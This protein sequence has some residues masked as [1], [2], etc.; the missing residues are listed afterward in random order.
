MYT[1]RKQSEI[2]KQL[3]R[4]KSLMLLFL[5]QKRYNMKRFSLEPLKLAA[6]LKTA[7]NF[8]KSRFMLS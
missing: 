6:A 1:Y 8:H 3:K 5:T 4:Y 7:G 2:S